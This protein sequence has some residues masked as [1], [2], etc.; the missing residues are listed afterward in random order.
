MRGRPRGSCQIRCP[1]SLPDESYRI[2]ARRIKN[3]SPRADAVE[4][5]IGRVLLGKGIRADLKSPN[6]ELRAV[7]T[8]GKIILGVE[9]ARVIAAPLRPAVPHLKPFFHPGVLMPRMARSL[10]I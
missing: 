3:A 5:E 4:H 1:L 9:V 10:V 7:I 6:I 2:R 8:S